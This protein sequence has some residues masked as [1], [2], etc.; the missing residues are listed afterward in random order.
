MYIG[1]LTQTERIYGHVYFIIMYDRYRDTF[2]LTV[3]YNGM[4][5]HFI[6]GDRVSS[7]DV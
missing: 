3:N 6:F 1:S 7:N 5:T 4:S 2:D